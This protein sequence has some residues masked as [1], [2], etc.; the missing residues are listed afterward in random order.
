LLVGLEDE[1]TLTAE[2]RH[3]RKSKE[4]AIARLTIEVQTL[5][6]GLAEGIDESKSKAKTAKWATERQHLMD[7]VTRF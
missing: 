2:L 3:E 7:D 5:T 4:A 1:Q 6:R